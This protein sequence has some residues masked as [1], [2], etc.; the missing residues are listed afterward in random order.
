MTPPR[1]SPP[2]TLPD[3][4][5][6]DQRGL[7]QQ[8]MQLI[9]EYSGK[10]WTDH[11][12][13]DP[14][15]TLLEAACEAITDLSY[16]MLHPVEDLIVSG[17][18]SLS[19]HFHEPQAALPPA[20][21]T[22]LDLRALLLLKHPELKNVWFNE[23]SSAAITGVFQISTEKHDSQ[24]LTANE[25]KE[26]IRR[27]LQEQ[28]NLG[29]TFSTISFLQTQEIKFCGEIDVDTADPTRIN[30]IN[31]E[32]QRLFD[33]Y[34][35][36]TIPSHS[37][38][39]GS[40][41]S[42]LNA[43]QL[44]TN[45]EYPDLWQ[46]PV[47]CTPANAPRIINLPALASLKPRRELRLSDLLS[48]IMDIDGVINVRHACLSNSDSGHQ[49]DNWIVEVNH[50]NVPK[51]TKT[52]YYYHRNKR[53]H[54]NE[55]EPNEP[56][57]QAPTVANSPQTTRVSDSDIPSGTSRRSR[58]DFP[59]L[60]SSLPE[61]YRDTEDRSAA[62]NP[63][64]TLL[65]ES[66]ETLDAT[67]GHVISAFQYRNH[68]STQT[69]TSEDALTTS[70]PQRLALIRAHMFARACDDN[71]EIK[72]TDQSTYLRDLLNLWR[73]RNTSAPGEASLKPGSPV[74]T[75]EARLRFL[76]HL[77]PRQQNQ[78][79]AAIKDSV[80]KEDLTT[81]CRGYSL[82]NHLDNPKVYAV[83]D[84]LLL[85]CEKQ[86]DG[87]LKY[88]REIDEKD[89][90]IAT[91]ITAPN[92]HNFEHHQ[93]LVNKLAELFHEGVYVIDYA[94]VLENAGQR[95]TPQPMLSSCCNSDKPGWMI[96][97]ILP[98]YAGRF[99]SIDR[100]QEVEQMIFRETP[101]HLMPCVR[102]VSFAGMQKLEEQLFAA[103]PDWSALLGVLNDNDLQTLHP[104]TALDAGSTIN[105]TAL[106]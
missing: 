46:T 22:E 3:D 45:G 27:T 49:C 40:L 90:D 48:L 41:S 70:P 47:D 20:P 24:P 91:T 37:I 60:Q 9:R 51:I 63:Y 93:D 58:H 64:Y 11:N 55:Q 16:R 13:H 12:L 30:E 32:I 17:G 102:W 84:P 73:N 72:F 15:V 50:E 5:A 100:R 2:T 43:L 85:V 86:S 82:E 31:T 54:F 10:T 99:V 103:T 53:M 78:K 79:L 18:G 97:I 1:L 38:Q 92:E 7:F 96:L 62:E 95:T 104:L 87:T 71:K 52:I 57:E 106:A 44:P 29:Q 83:A 6:F 80:K 25:L 21:T 74:W 94:Q 88:K 28:R 23:D 59:T 101:A 105:R 36:P 98:A 39:R 26:R 76:L 14:G 19:V 68:D 67:L 77:P 34:C 75:L 81:I 42:L 35:S 65:N 89:Y 66:F 8:G 33:E 61:L 69:A 56:P 4:P